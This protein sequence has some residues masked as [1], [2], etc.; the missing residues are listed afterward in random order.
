MTD[1]SE[2]RVRPKNNGVGADTRANKREDFTVLPLVFSLRNAALFVAQLVPAAM[3]AYV[4][5]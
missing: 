5:T 1:A 3:S 2:F 4:G